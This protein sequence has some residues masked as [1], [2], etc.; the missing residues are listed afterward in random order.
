MERL[1]GAD[2]GTDVDAYACRLETG[3]LNGAAIDIA[4][5]LDGDAELVLA[6]AGRDIRVRLGEDVWIDAQGD[7]GSLARSAGALAEDF[8]FRFTLHVEEEDVCVEGGVDLPDLLADAGEDDAAE[9]CG[10]GAADAF[11]LAA[12]DDVEAATLLAEQLEDGQRGVGFDRVAESVWNRGELCL[13]HCYA[14]ADGVGG[15]DVERR[16]VGF[17]QL[18]EVGARTGQ[19]VVGVDERAGRCGRAHVTMVLGLTIDLTPASAFAP[20]QAVGPLLGAA[21]CGAGGA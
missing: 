13:E 6:Q 3:K 12:R 2:L 8:Q 1:D 4:G 15:V 19:A 17:G 16:A 14:L 21:G 9:G 18:R 11:E 7:L 20:A 10:C 5:A